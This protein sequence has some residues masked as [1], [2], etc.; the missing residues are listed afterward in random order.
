MIVSLIKRQLINQQN[1]KIKFETP[2]QKEFFQKMKA[3][4][5]EKGK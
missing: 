1:T 3:K 5:Q 4:I 2:V